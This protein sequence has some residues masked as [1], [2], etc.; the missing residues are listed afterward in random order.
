MD[1]ISMGICV[2]FSLHTLTSRPQDDR[3]ESTRVCVPGVLPGNGDPI[4]VIRRHVPELSPPQ[5]HVNP[6]P[7]STGIP[8]QTWL[9][10]LWDRSARFFGLGFFH[11]S[12]LYGPQIRGYKDFLFFFVFGKLF[13]YFDESA[14]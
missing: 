3:R 7:H 5:A 14:L 11:G 2:V 8:L 12:T 4:A 13:E 1:D 6:D 9:P 10:L